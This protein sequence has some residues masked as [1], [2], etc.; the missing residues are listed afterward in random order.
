MRHFIWIA[1]TTLGLSLSAYADSTLHIHNK[2][3]KSLALR[4]LTKKS[5]GVNLAREIPAHSDIEIA[6]DS[7]DFK[8]EK[9]YDIQGETHLFIGDKCKNLQV[10][11]DYTITFTNDTIGTTCHAEKR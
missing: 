3:D 4:L 1:V 6:L 7:N 9:T 2:N 10:D 5:D 8:G 11:Q